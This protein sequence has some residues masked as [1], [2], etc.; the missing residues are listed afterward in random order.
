MESYDYLLA[1]ETQSDFDEA[2]ISVLK[3]VDKKGWTVF[4][5]YD[6]KERMAVKGFDQKPLKIIEICSAKH[7]NRILDKNRY[8]SLCMPCRINV[9]N[10]NNKIRII[11][12]KPSVMP[13][14]FHE[15]S[16]ADVAE[17][18]KDIIDMIN[19]AR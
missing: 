3:A 10:D 7:S 12:M 5:I 11:A 2:V 18:E 1:V 14:F 8:A 17:I 4:Q 13:V 6:L 16:Q 9:I 19:E 15:I